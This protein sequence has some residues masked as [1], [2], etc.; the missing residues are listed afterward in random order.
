MF[1]RTNNKMQRLVQPPFGKYSAYTVT[2]SSESS[3]IT[4]TVDP[5]VATEKAA[6]DAPV[7]LKSS[8]P[9]AMAFARL[10]GI[11][12][13]APARK[14]IPSLK[15]VVFSPRPVC[16]KAKPSVFVADAAQD[17]RSKH[18]AS[19]AKRLSARP[20]K[21]ESSKKMTKKRLLDDE[22]EENGSFSLLESDDEDDEDDD[23]SD[24][25][26]FIDD[27]ECDNDMSVYFQSNF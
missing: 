17:G 11:N 8:T 10:F 23:G 27:T 20:K 12:E 2:A 4:V 3:D 6:T 9:T 5:K 24:L 18:S 13:T 26:G 14:R 16:L 19:N 22:T 15:T 7:V 1:R 21:S 25:I